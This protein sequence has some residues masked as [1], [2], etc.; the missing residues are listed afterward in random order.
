MTT[1]AM[2]TTGATTA[3][4]NS[5]RDKRPPVTPINFYDPIQQHPP[6]IPHLNTSSGDK[7]ALPSPKSSRASKQIDTTTPVNKVCT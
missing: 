4:T 3:T 5:N 6:A 2:T 1:T 7:Y